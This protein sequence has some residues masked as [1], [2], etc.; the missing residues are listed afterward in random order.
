MVKTNTNFWRLSRQSTATGLVLL[1]TMVGFAPVAEAGMWI[2]R[3]WSKVQRVAPGTRT[4]VLL[5][6][7]R[8][9]GGLRKIEGRFKSATPEAIT[10]SLPGGNPYTLQ[11]Q[12]VTKVLVYRPLSKRYPGWITLGVSASWS[13]PTVAKAGS[14][15][16]PWGKWFLNGVFISVPT[17][18]A[19]LVAPR[20][21]G[22]YNVP[23][24][25][26]DDPAP[27]PSP[28]PDKQSSSTTASSAKDAPTDFIEAGSEGYFLS[29]KSG[30]ELLRLQSRR[31]VM[32]QDLPLDLSSLPVH[33]H[34][35]GID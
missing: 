1:L 15:I 11:K 26:R 12:D 35:S 28:P 3:D 18:I 29:G 2:R 19:F 20:W 16:E 4:T 30:P 14:D 5:Y 7:D 13:I 25:L 31:A 10:L 9:P 24:K 8:A 17:V 22:V 32:R 6:K 21:G 34:R 27:E 23:R 33:A